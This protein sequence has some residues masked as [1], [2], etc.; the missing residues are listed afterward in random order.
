VM[1]I[2]AAPHT[3]T[4]S[5]HHISQAKCITGAL[6]LSH[7]INKARI[8]MAVTP[9]IMSHKYMLQSRLVTSYFLPVSCELLY[10][11]QI[12]ERPSRKCER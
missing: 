12:V 1:M 3:H 2:G 6:T 7:K 10:T 9:K 8:S 4:A 11:C 5:P